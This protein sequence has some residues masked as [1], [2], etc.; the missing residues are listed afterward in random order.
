[1]ENIAFYITLLR[2]KMWHGWHQDVL[3]ESYFMELELLPMRYDTSKIIAN[4]KVSCFEDDELK[5]TNP[6]KRWVDGCIFLEFSKKK[7]RNPLSL[8]NS[9]N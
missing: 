8:Q 9:S 4:C 7:S 3:E 6:P 2:P 1:M 5:H